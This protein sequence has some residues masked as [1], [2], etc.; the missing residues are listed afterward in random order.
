MED[1]NN[2]PFSSKDID[3]S[4][5]F[6]VNVHAVYT[7]EKLVFFNLKNSPENRT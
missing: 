2:A 4:T 5:S 1:I 6:V 7:N 3:F